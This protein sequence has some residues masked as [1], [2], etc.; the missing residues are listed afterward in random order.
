MSRPATPVQ[1]PAVWTI[2]S[3][4]SWSEGYFRDK[5]IDTPR[6]DSELLLAHVLR[7]ERIELYL[8][9]DRPLD[10][11]EL[12]AYRE[13]VRA[14]AGRRPL[15][16]LLGQAG[17]WN[18]KLSVGPGCLIPRADTEALVETALEALD[19]LRGHCE[20]GQPLRLLEFGT[21]SGAIPLALCAERENL[22]CVACDISG[23]ALGFARA[24]RDSHAQLLAPRQ[25]ALHL[26]RGDGFD[27]LSPHWRPH[28][29]L[30]NP[31]YIPSAELSTLE[32]EV[33]REEPASALDGGAD[34]LVIYRKLLPLAARVLEPGGRLLLEFGMGQGGALRELAAAQP[35]LELVEIRK[36][37]AGRERVLHAVRIPAD[38]RERD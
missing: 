6:L 2:R 18:L 32:P 17:F 1:P 31:P 27:A 9:F 35:A 14:R 25:N 16:Y 22:L 10:N 23:E 7:C 3:L 26:F 20:A 38:A 12:A 36:D 15:A 13:L 37:L 19:A 34:G 5:G 8:Q 28:L 30:A 33:S 29:I 24:N 4:L 11:T 21:G